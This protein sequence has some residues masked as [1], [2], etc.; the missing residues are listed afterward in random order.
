[1]VMPSICFRFWGF[2]LTIPGGLTLEGGRRICS[3]QRLWV[4]LENVISWD[5]VRSNKDGG[6]Q[7]HQAVTFSTVPLAPAHHKELETDGACSK[8]P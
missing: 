1:M 5:Q 8:T 6:I 2:C 4:P 7:N 3:A